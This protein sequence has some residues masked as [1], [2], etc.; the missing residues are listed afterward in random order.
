MTTSASVKRSRPPAVDGVTRVG[1][2]RGKAFKSSDLRFLMAHRLKA[3]RFAYKENASEFARDMG[4]TPQVLNAYEKGRNFPD[5]LFLVNFFEKTGCTADWI[6][7]GKMESELPAAMAS[8]IAHFF[9]Y[10]LEEM[11][12]T[13]KKRKAVDLVSASAS[14]AAKRVLAPSDA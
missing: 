13:S 9:S 5:E 3:A 8:R 4:I 10:L 2:S 7:R 6:F 11:P 12:E 1:G 14:A